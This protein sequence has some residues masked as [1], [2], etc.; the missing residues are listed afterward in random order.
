MLIFNKISR[1]N[2]ASFIKAMVLFTV[3]I[4]VIILMVDF[5]DNLKRYGKY[6]MFNILDIIFITFYK[7]P[8]LIIELSPF[9]I[10]FSS[11]MA[12][13]TSVLKRELDIYKACGLSIWKFLYPYIAIVFLYSLVCVLL[14]SS[15][16][17]YF[18]NKLDDVEYAIKL[19]KA[20]QDEVVILDENI[21]LI[22]KGVDDKDYYLLAKSIS[23]YKNNNAEEITVLGNLNIFEINNSKVIN[24]LIAQQGKLIGHNINLQNVIYKNDKTYFPANIKELNIQTKVKTSSISRINIEPER[25][26]IWNLPNMIS[27]LNNIGLDSNSYSTYFYKMLAFPILLM[28]ML[29]ISVRFS[30][31][32][33]RR[34]KNLYAIFATVLGGV[35]GYFFTNFAINLGNSG[36][37]NPGIAVFA[38]HIIFFLLANI[39][40]VYK[41]GI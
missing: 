26:L 19:S 37:I 18:N 29:F 22:I 7:L 11:L 31:Y 36:A 12:I 1:Y 3:F 5:T 9:I 6:D 41:E 16:S 30:L 21:W 27:N 34:G 35:A 13:R 25:I 20:E 40:L 14:L 32:D 24:M 10:L 28:G 23:K 17:V 4:S 33:L 15:L 2:G 38:S 39:S 8:R